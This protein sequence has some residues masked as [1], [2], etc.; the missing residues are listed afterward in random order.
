M[1]CWSQSLGRMSDPQAS[2]A[3]QL[4]APRAPADRHSVPAFLRLTLLCARCPRAG[5]TWCEGREGPGV[6]LGFLTRAV[7]RMGVL[8]TRIR[9]LEVTPGRVGASELTSKAA[10]E[11]ADRCA[12]SGCRGLWALQCVGGQE[13]SCLGG[14]TE[15]PFGVRGRGGEVGGRVGSDGPR[16]GRSVRGPERDKRRQDGDCRWPWWRPGRFAKSYFLP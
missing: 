9:S 10:A 5:L 3:P 11:E 15:V 16:E 6:T 8:L 14:A 1:C 13:A 12:T 7:W 4:P 2:V